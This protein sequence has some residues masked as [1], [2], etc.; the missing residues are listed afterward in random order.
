MRP[1]GNCCLDHFGLPAVE[2][3]SKRRAVLF[4]DAATECCVWMLDITFRPTALL[5]ERG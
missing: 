4:A 1:S 5:C 3:Q 2:E